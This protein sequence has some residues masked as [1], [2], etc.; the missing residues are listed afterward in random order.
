MLSCEIPDGCRAAAGE[1]HRRYSYGRPFRSVRYAAVGSRARKKAEASWVVSGNGNGS[2]TKSRLKAT[3]T[4]HGSPLITGHCSRHNPS[5]F[6]GGRSES[7]KS[8]DVGRRS[9][10]PGHDGPDNTFLFSLQQ[11]HV[12]ARAPA[13][14]TELYPPSV[15]RYG[16]PRKARQEWHERAYGGQWE[17]PGSPDSTSGA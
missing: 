1:M 2:V 14:S 17:S 10:C 7:V 5:A 8:T 6:C 3:V 9:C 12:H 13:P 4:A 15:E 16:W 11:I